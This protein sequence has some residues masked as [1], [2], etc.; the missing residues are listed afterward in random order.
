MRGGGFAIEL[1]DLNTRL[2]ILAEDVFR[3][4]AVHD[5]GVGRESLYY[6]CEALGEIAPVVS[7]A[8]R[9]VGSNSDG[10]SLGYS[11]AAEAVSALVT[12]TDV[13]DNFDSVGLQPEA[14]CSAAVDVPE[15]HDEGHVAVNGEVRKDD[16]VEALE[17]VEVAPRVALHPFEQVV[18]LVEMYPLVVILA[19][20]CLR[21]GNQPVGN[22]TCGLNDWKLEDSCVVCER[23]KECVKHVLAALRVG[24]EFAHRQPPENRRT[25]LMVRL[26]SGYLS[27]N[28]LS[29]SII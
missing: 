10:A 19:A 2:T 28:L 18:E 25:L 21:E 13:Y 26:T 7:A 22:P 9:A 14:D 4:A 11:V 15:L 27:A 8:N 3:C 23:D 1:D 29:S 20:Y 12:P 16:A 24:F 6:D 5:D 17:D